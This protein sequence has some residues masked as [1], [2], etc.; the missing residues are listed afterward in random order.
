M[1]IIITAKDLQKGQLFKKPRQ[2]KFKY[3]K[4]L[5]RFATHRIVKD[6]DTE[7]I[8]AVDDE[9]RQHL[10]SPSESIEIHVDENRPEDLDNYFLDDELPF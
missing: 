1:R 4:E 8:L 3:C 2:H 7:V 10:L 9:C 6:G 5:Y